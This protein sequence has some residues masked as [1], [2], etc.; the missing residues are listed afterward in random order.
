MKKAIITTIFSCKG[1]VGKTTFTNNLAGIFSLKNKK[2]LIID[3]DLSSGGVATTLNVDVKNDICDLVCD[4]KSGKFK[5]IDDYVCNYDENIDVISSPI[6]TRNISKIKAKYID[7]LISRCDSKYDVILIDTSHI[8]S[9]INLNVLDR[10]DKI[11]LI[12]TNDPVDLKNTKNM[13]NILKETDNKYSVVLNNSKDT[14]KDFFSLYDIKSIINNNIDYIIPSSFFI[15]DIDKYVID[16]EILTMV[17]KIR[18]SKKS[19]IDKYNLIAESLLNE[20]EE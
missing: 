7:L 14:G 4:I 11:L 18:N 12:V 20:S 3:L 5:D 13:L 1:G 19:D 2:V 10:S 15:K 17:N 8:L 9:S 6:D 16:G